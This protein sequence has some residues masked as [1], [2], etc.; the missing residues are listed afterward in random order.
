[1]EQ[2]GFRLKREKKSEKKQLPE[3]FWTL[4]GKSEKP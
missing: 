2:S 3:D 4:K 1:M